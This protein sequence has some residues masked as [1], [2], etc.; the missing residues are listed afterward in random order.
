MDCVNA[1]QHALT[2]ARS[3]EG[4]TSPRPP[5]GAVVIQNGVIVGKGA[6]APPYGPHAEIQAL[7]QAGS[8]AYGADLYVTLEPCSIFVHTPPCTDA[9]IA[10]GIRRV[11]VGTLDPNPRVQG[12]GIEKLRRADI[13]VSLL[14]ITMPAA[15]EAYE[16]VRPFEIYIRQSRPY[17]TA[18]WAMTLDGKIASATG[19]AYWVSG[20]DAR[21]W[22]HDLRDR[23]DAILVGAGTARIDNPQ[24]T[25]RLPAD[26]QRWPRTPRPKPPLRVV[27]ATTGLLPDSL[28]LLQPELASGTLVLVGET[29]SHKQCQQ[30]AAYGVEVL[31]VKL[32]SSGHI[33]IREAIQVLEQRGIMHLLIEGGAQ[34][35]GSAFDQDCIDHIAVFIAPRL[36]GGRDAYSPIEGKGLSIMAQTRQVQHMRMDVINGD[37]LLEGDITPLDGHPVKMPFSIEG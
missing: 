5:V 28:S 37:V 22:G 19:D 6:T 11:I 3:V 27:L 34:I 9:I 4:R 8:A 17:V 12:Q 10:A 23:V 25:V 18:K 21:M 13:E 36:I 7:T 31:S 20:P 29:C 26:K 33:D 14:V 15:Q 32:D 24:L 35:L 30:L 2:C 16:I 1:M